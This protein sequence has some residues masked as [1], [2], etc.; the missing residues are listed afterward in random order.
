MIAGLLTISA[1]LFLMSR[2]FHGI[3]LFSLVVGDFALLAVFV[4]LTGIGMGIANP[5]ANNAL[6][7][8]MPHKAAAITGLRGTFRTT[9]GVIGNT[10]VI[11]VLSHFHDRVAGM[12]DLYFSFALL[13]LLL[14][15]LVF[16]IPDMA[17]ERRNKNHGSPQ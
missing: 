3:T 10:V 11:L 5:A 15:P 2:G 7:D 16:M 12:H 17:Q 14:V 6:I 1:E 9:G 13:L 8:L 4:M